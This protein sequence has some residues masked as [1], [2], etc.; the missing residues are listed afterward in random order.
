MQPEV[1]QPEELCARASVRLHEFD[2]M[3]GE[4][5]PAMP[6]D[7]DASH[8]SDWQRLLGRALEA[9]RATGRGHLGA[10]D[11]VQWLT[12]GPE[13]E[14]RNAFDDGV[15]ASI[16]VSR[17]APSESAL[18]EATRARRLMIR[19]LAWVA[20]TSLPLYT[21][22][23]RGGPDAFYFPAAW[24]HAERY[25]LALVDD[26]VRLVHAGHRSHSLF[27]RP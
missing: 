19:A 18:A 14:P 21:G 20:H 22:S 9:W 6:R 1:M 16:Y 15:E 2:Y 4:W 17:K 24:E 10:V 12:Y 5:G 27:A 8:R 13:H 26:E 11:F 7:G 3:I 25:R 23:E